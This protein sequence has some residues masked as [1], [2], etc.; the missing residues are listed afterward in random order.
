L[1]II[2]HPFIS[3]VVA[4]SVPVTVTA[5]DKP[6]ENN[7]NN[8]PPAKKATEKA[9]KQIISNK[10]SEDAVEL[11]NKD[12]GQKKVSTNSTKRIGKSQSKIQDNS[13]CSFY[14]TKIFETL[15]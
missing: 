6:A 13:Y 15:S 5:N 1:F 12:D 10:K 4:A 8:D 7:N 14:G 9:G 3:T 2:P 11:T